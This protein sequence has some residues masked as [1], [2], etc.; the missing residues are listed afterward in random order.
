[1]PQPRKYESPAAKQAAYRARKQ[2]IAA[3]RVA[4]GFSPFPSPSPT[5]SLQYRAWR[6][7]IAQANA[8]LERVY[9][10][11]NEWMQERSERWQESDRGFALQADYERLEA[12]L[13][14]L[15]ELEALMPS[16]TGRGKGDGR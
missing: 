1:M 14:S 13:E 12:V 4:A 16:S 9:E 15:A 8:A 11:V 3:A 6:A 10:E 7:T 5:A 2:T